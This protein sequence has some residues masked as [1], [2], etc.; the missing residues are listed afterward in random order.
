MR[1][2]KLLSLLFLAITFLAVSCTKEGPEGPAG[3]TGAQGPAGGSGPA[4]P[5]GPT[6][7]T[8]P[9]GPTGPTGPTGTANVIYGA[10]VPEGAWA[11]TSMASINVGGGLARRFIVAAPALSNTILDQGVVLTYIKTDLSPN[12]PILLPWNISAGANLLQVASRATTQ[13]IVYFFYF[14]NAPT[15]QPTGA[16]GANAQF[17]YILIPGGVAGRT[18]DIAGTGHTLDEIKAMP[19]KEVCK[20]LRIPE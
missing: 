20:L 12:S 2:I 18:T 3:A 13:K 5:A 19:Y 15:T 16:L 4:G 8:G 1:K 10:W 11:D 6:G 9:A 17:R 7:P 14:V